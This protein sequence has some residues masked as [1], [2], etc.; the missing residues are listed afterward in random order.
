MDAKL[1]KIGKIRGSGR[2]NTKRFNRR[3]KHFRR[4]RWGEHK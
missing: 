2:G 1:G 3:G 4:T